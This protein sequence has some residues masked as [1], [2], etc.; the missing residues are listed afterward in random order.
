[1]V[2]HK[3]VSLPVTLPKNIG[4]AEFAAIPETFLTGQYILLS[5][6]CDNDLDSIAWGTLGKSLN[7][8]SEDTL[9]IRGGTTSVGLAM[10]TL[11]KTLFAVPKVIATTRSS[12]KID[13]LTAVGVDHAIVDTG[14]VSEEVMRLTDG[15]GVTKCVELVGATAL[16]D[17][18][19][20]LSSHGV[21]TFVGGVSGQFVVENFDPMGSLA[22][23]KVR[24]MLPFAKRTTAANTFHISI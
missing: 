3:S 16:P 24:A 2:P 8:T 7:L 12:A 11:A 5:A 13:V 20:S 1:M 14:N 6:Y 10:A 21:I 17:S 15:K 23:F 19:A 22:P 4:W 18:C 9:L